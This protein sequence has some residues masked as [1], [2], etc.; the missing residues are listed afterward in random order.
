L[1]VRLLNGQG[2]MLRRCG[3][4]REACEMHQEAAQLATGRG[5]PLLAA[6]AYY[7]LAQALA[8]GQQFQE[9]ATYAQQALDSFATQDPDSVWH[10]AG[11]TLRGDLARKLS[12]LETAV[13]LLEQATMLYRPFSNKKT[14]LA[15]VLNNLALAHQ[16]QEAW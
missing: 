13:R 15:L 11:L 14:Q 16:E 3:R 5:D 4:W 10:A 8:Q 6:Q 1:H 2:V 7:F 12:D 9:A